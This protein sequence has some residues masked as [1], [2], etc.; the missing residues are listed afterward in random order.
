MVVQRRVV[1]ATVSLVGIWLAVGF[2][3]VFGR[4]IVTETGTARGKAGTRSR[5]PAVVPVAAFAGAATLFV[6]WFGFRSGEPRATSGSDLGAPRA[7]VE[8][9]SVPVPQDGPVAVE[10]S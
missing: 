7:T 6:A 9:D 5:V 4:D 8:R 3:G 10:S 2:V 1:G